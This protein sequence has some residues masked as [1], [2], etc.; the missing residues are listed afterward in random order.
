LGAYRAQ[1][2]SRVAIRRETIQLRQVLGID[3]NTLYFPVI[4]LFEI[5]PLIYYGLNTEIVEDSELPDSFAETD[6]MKK[7]IKVRESIYNAACNGDGF[8]R[9][10]IMHEIG[11][12]HLLV[13]NSLQLQRAVNE[14]QVKPYED[15]E[16]HAKC[17]AGE[18][19]I[20]KRL[21]KGMTIEEIAKKCGVTKSAA[22][23]Q[24]KKYNEE[25]EKR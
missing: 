24:L 4:K 1:P 11:H 16:W 25:K 8:A 13:E 17:F 12:Y 3:E 9:M 23:Y 14:H 6:V 2:L 22:E 21:V 10:T 5:L 15:P 20:P 18:I 19:M 7:T